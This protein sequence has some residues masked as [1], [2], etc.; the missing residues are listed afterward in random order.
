[1]RQP[2]PLTEFQKRNAH[3]TEVHLFIEPARE[4]AGKEEKTGSGI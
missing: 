3:I 4:L 1:M 2:P